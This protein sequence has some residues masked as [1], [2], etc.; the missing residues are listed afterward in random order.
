MK[1]LLEDINCTMFMVK[2]PD[3]DQSEIIIRFKFDSEQEAL[4]F[5]DTFKSTPEYTDYAQTG[6]TITYH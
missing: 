2:N 4:S 1:E 6:K 5:A 3:T